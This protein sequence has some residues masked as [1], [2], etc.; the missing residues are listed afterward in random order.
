[1]HA[2]I[3][4]KAA[5]QAYC[6]S[7]DIFLPVCKEPLVILENTWV[8]VSKLDY[9]NFTVYVLDDGGHDDVQELAKMFGFQCKFATSGPGTIK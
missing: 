2:E 7:V 8:Y 1:M 6:P 5:E 4:R 3:V 9:P